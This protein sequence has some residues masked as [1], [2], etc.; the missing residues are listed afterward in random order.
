MQIRHMNVSV[1]RAK[2][3]HNAAA[4][5][6]SACT[7]TKVPNEAHGNTKAHAGRAGRRGQA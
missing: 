2:S 5:A 4:A 3:Q 6:A 1:T 7:V